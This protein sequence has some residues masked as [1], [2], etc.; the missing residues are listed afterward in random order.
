M[1]K[2]KRRTYTEDVEEKRRTENGNRRPETEER[3]RKYFV[4]FV[5]Y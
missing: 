4:Q 2:T 5:G 1:I 3:K